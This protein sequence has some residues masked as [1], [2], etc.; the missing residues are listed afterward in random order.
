MKGG[1]VC[2]T[3]GGSAR[4][5]KNA[6]AEREA[7][8]KAEISAHKVFGSGTPIDHREAAV[9][10]LHRR[11][12]MVSWYVAEISAVGS[13]IGD[14]PSALLGL[15]D[16]AEKRLNEIL[17]LCH[18]MR[19]DQQMLDLARAHADQTDRIIHALIRGLGHDPAD[20]AVRK[21][22]RGTLELVDGGLAS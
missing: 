5:V 4:Q 9:S 10:T 8:A 15:L 16:K 6:A 19:I 18:D 20:P 17:R 2:R 11:Y 22:V 3:H 1:M 13:V 21:V 12:A 14:R 7:E